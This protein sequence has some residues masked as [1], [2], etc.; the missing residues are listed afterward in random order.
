MTLGVI[1]IYSLL[2]ATHRGNLLKQFHKMAFTLRHLIIFAS[3]WK[4]LDYASE[5]FESVFNHRDM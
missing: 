3:L 2:T 1:F 5:F 4:I